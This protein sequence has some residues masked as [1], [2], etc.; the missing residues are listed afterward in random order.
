MFCASVLRTHFG[1]KEFFSLSC[2]HKRPTLDLE[3][4]SLDF[5]IQRSVESVDANKCFHSEYS[6]KTL[7]KPALFLMALCDCKWWM[8]EAFAEQQQ[9]IKS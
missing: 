4:F 7:A 2:F 8:K 6:G 9:C 1:V 3:T 5:Y